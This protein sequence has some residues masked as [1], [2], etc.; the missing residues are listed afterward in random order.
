MSFKVHVGAVEAPK[1][2]IAERQRVQ[3]TWG[4][5]GNEALEKLRVA[6]PGLTYM[7][8]APPTFFDEV[9]V[10][11]VISLLQWECPRPAGARG[12]FSTRF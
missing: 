1:V 5:S 6:T 7:S 4:I 2:P 10:A 8:V 11:A 3:Q 12:C 9:K